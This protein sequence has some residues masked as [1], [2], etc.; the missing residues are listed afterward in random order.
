MTYAITPKNITL[1]S[2]IPEIIP[3][4]AAPIFIARY[5]FV[6]TAELK[7]LENDDNH[8]NEKQIK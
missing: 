3:P 4:S 6:Q 1:I 8:N 5:S 7:Q 2:R